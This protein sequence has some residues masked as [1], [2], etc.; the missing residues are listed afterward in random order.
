MNTEIDISEILIEFCL[1]EIQLA[2]ICSAFNGIKLTD[3]I[4]GISATSTKGKS[5]SS[6]YLVTLELLKLKLVKQ[7]F[8]TID[9]DD[10]VNGKAFFKSLILENMISIHNTCTPLK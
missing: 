6:N 2:H 4:S 9:E 5:Q 10:L 3:E 8:E 7:R 1:V